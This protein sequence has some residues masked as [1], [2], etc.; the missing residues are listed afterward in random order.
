MQPVAPTEVMIFEILIA[1]LIMMALI[2]CCCKIHNNNNN[3]AWRGFEASPAHWVPSHEERSPTSHYIWRQQPQV[4]HQSVYYSDYAWKDTSYAA[5][6]FTSQA[7]HLTMPK[8]LFHGFIQD[9][10]TTFKQQRRANYQFAV[11]FLSSQDN[12]A[13]IAR[14]MKFC[15]SDRKCSKYNATDNR[16]PTFPPSEKLFNYITARPD[17]SGNHAEKLILEKFGALIQSY[18]YYCS[19]L[20]S[21]VLYTWLLP[22]K[23]CQKEIVRVLG[24]YCQH[25]KVMVVYSSEGQQNSHQVKEVHKGFRQAG[26]IVKFEQCD[27][28]L[29]QK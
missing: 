28:A 8:T 29:K 20:K 17:E 1:I 15:T 27:F 3:N 5:D 6:C 11:L 12:E 9:V 26:I 18:R 2:W 22:C 7:A 25:S 14:K 10:I 4:A 16:F 13:D 19:N 24:L 21:I 23:T